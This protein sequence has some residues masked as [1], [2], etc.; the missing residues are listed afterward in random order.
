MRRRRNAI[1]RTTF[2]CLSREFYISCYANFFQTKWTGKATVIIQAAFMIKLVEIRVIFILTVF[3]MLVLCP[4]ISPSCSKKFFSSASL[5]ILL[6]Q[7]VPEYILSYDI[8]IH[9]VGISHS[10]VK[11]YAYCLIEELQRNL[12][13]FFQYL[14][15]HCLLISCE[16][17]SVS[18]S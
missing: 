10:Q 17:T 2:G 6:T 11:R 1:F 4:S 9:K 15:N 3:L 18:T 13:S 12:C 16:S 8:M 5:R 7:S 14:I